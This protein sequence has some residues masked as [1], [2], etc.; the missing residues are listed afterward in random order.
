MASKSVM[1]GKNTF[2][3]SKLDLYRP[4]GNHQP[5]TC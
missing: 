3:A 4:P 1:W 2:T 5:R